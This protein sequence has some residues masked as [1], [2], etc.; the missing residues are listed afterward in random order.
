MNTTSPEFSGLEKEYTSVLSTAGSSEI[1]GASRWL[2][3]PATVGSS[4]ITAAP[5]T[6]PPEAKRAVA[7]V[8]GLRT[9]PI[10]DIRRSSAPRRGPGLDRLDVAVG[11]AGT[12]HRIA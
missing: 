12:A 7:R 10:L 9:M 3:A 11:D 8:A 1:S 4:P 6:S 5:A 2:E